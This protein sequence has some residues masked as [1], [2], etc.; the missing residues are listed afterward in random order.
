MS[1]NKIKM[2]SAKEVTISP[3][4]SFPKFEEYSEKYKDFVIMERRDGVIMLRMHTNNKPIIWNGQIHRAIHQ[5]VNE[6]ARDPENQVMILTATGDFWVA[7]GFAADDGNALKEDDSAQRAAAA[8]HIYVGDG[9]PLQENL[10]FDVDVPTIGA[11]T[12]PGYHNEMALHCDLT[13]CSENTVMLDVHRW[14]G[15]VSGDG[16]NIAYQEFMGTKRANYAML[17]GNPITA[18]Q[19]L[20]WGMVNEVVPRDRLYD[21]AWEMG[22]QIMKYGDWGHRRMMTEIMRKPL[23]K[24][25]AEDFAGAFAMEMYAYLCDTSVSHSDDALAEMWEQAGVELPDWH[26]LPE[27]L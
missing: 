12:G 18:Q 24:R 4:V 11:I 10:I 6:V 26:T 8:K 21:R 13:I 7:Y 16:I 27:V 14:M 2:P 17:M 23:K 19:A 9:M 20:D 3:F 22:A 1:K 15:F 25:M 5:A